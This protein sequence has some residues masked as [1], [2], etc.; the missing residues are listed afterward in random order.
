MIASI[1]EIIF[2]FILVD[3]DLSLLRVGPQLVRVIRITRVAK[4]IRLIRALKDIQ[5]IL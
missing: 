2:G 5:G 4:L 3:N 1:V